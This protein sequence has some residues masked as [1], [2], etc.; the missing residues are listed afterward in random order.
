MNWVNKKMILEVEHWGFLPLFC[1]GVL[2]WILSVK[3]EQNDLFSF[4]LLVKLS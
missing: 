4:F 1:F 2:G 3:K